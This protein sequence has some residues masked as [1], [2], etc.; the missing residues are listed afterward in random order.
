MTK[1]LKVQLIHNYAQKTHT[2]LHNYTIHNF[3]IF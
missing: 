2:I 3:G 1:Q